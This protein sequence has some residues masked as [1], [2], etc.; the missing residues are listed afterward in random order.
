MRAS[1]YCKDVLTKHN[2]HASEQS[3]ALCNDCKEWFTKHRHALC[4]D[5]RLCK[6]IARMGS[7]GII[8]IMGLQ[9]TAKCEMH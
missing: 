6:N 1:K 4:I 8:I 2:Q 3:Y 5:V 7:M 9:K